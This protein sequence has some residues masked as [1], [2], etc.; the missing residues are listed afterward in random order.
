MQFKL[1]SHNWVSEIASLSLSWISMP[2]LRTTI[3]GLTFIPQL[4]FSLKASL[5][6]PSNL[7]PFICWFFKCVKSK[8]DSTDLIS[9]SGFSYA[10]VSG[11]LRYFKNTIQNIIFSKMY[12]HQLY[13][14]IQLLFFNLCTYDRILSLYMLLT[15]LKKQR[16]AKDIWGHSLVGFFGFISAA[17]LLFSA[18]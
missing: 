10:W 9:F 18:G 5:W 4:L 7:L 17:A 16:Q 11:I 3:K 1:Q 8:S 13:S 15:E 14:F 6:I 2:K 12:N